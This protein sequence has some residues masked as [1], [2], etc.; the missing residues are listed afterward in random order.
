MTKKFS[1][2]HLPVL[3]V[4]LFFATSAPMMATNI[5]NINGNSGVYNISPEKAIGNLGFREYKD[6]ELSKGHTANLKFNGINT[7]VNMVDNQ[8]N[9]NGRVNTVDQAGAFYNGAAVFVSPKGMVVGSDGVLN[10]GALSVL[11]PTAPGMRMLKDGV[12]AGNLTTTYKGK[13]IDLME[14]MGWHGNAPVTINGKVF[15]RGDVEIVANQFNLAK[16]AGIAAGVSELPDDLLFDALVNTGK[17][18]NVNIRTYDRSNGKMQINGNIVNMGKGDMKLQNRGSN[19]LTIGQDAVIKNADGALHIVNS[20]GAMN[21]EG[22]VE[23]AGD[24][25]YFTNGQKAGA[26]NLAGNV[27]SDAGLQVYNRSNAGANVGGKIV[28]TGKGFAVTNE[29][30]VLNLDAEIQNKDKGMF[31][32]NTGSKLVVDNKITSTGK[33]Q[34]ANSGKDGMELNGV[35]KNSKNTAITNHNGKLLVNGTV[36]NTAG[37]MNI[38]QKGDEGLVLAADSKILGAGEEVLVQNVGKGGFTANGTVDSSTATFL[39]NTKG[40]MVVN[41]SV[42]NSD[43]VLYIGNTGAGGLKITDKADISNNASIQIM[44]NGAAGMNIEGKVN[45]N[46]GGTAITNRAGDMNVKGFVES[47]EGNINLTNVGNGALN[48]AKNANVGSEKGQLVVQNT[49]E[50]GMNINGSVDN[51]GYTVVYNKAGDLNVNGDVTVRGA[52]LSVNN[53]GAGAL[54]INDG[55]K[56]INE[57]LGR[58]YITNQGKGGMEVDAPVVGGGHILLTNRAGGMHVA[59]KVA[60]TKS[61][62]VLTNTGEKNMVVDGTVRG[63]K[64]TAYSK[65]NDIVLGN[66]ETEQIAIHGLKKVAITTDNGSILNAGVDKHLIKSGGNLYMAANKGSIG[67]SVPAG[68]GAK[69][70]DL[71]KSVNVYVNGKVKAFT[72]DSKKASDINIASKGKDLKV[73]RIKADGKVFLL[74][75]KYT[76]KNGK[77][78]TGSILNA[79]TELDKYANVKGTTVNM[80]SS[81]AIGTKAKPIHFRQTDATQKSSVLAVK[82]VNLHARGEAAGEKVNFSTIKS[83]KGSLEVNIIRDGVVDRAI[84]PKDVNV[85]ARK[86]GANLKVKSVSHNPNVIKDY[87]DAD[88]D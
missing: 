26:M 5:T 56:V 19:G 58:T 63:N 78:H 67:K 36:Q 39:Q 33:V 32:T 1:K 71:T 51:R 48:I 76:D 84:A 55:A 13:E 74:T 37:K 50:G 62:V 23:G 54:K 53:T 77:V 35:I 81:G 44:N 18:S 2:R 86:E 11:T 9:V 17:D 85:Y 7:F 3:L 70:R 66:K 46:G 42:A 38:T 45:N 22:T 27:K 69:S 25:V 21:V 61:N 87:F 12:A 14:A 30:G 72:T 60:S 28:N 59:D 79:G 88:V 6:F 4:A 16:D 83:K 29:A 34:I 20:K 82:D 10:V 64:V 40:A 49:A 31:I 43:K 47:K 73:N 68:I 8:I 24:Y 80:I 15:S 41:G 52:R 75:D 65:G 57:G